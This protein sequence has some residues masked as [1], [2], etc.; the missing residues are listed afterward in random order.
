MNQALHVLTPAQVAAGNFKNP[1]QV[2]GALRLAEIQWLDGLG[3]GRAEWM[4]LTDKQYARW[5]CEGDERLALA[6]ELLNRT[7]RVITAEP[8]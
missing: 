3:K 7:G 2:I 1:D 8:W 6:Q 5:R 4:G